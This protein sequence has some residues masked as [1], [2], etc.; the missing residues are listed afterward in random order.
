MKKDESIKEDPLM[1]KMDGMRKKWQ[2]VRTPG[3]LNMKKDESIKEDPLMPKMNLTQQKWQTE[4]K[5][6]HRCFKKFINSLNSIASRQS[7]GYHIQKFM[8]FCVKENKIT[9]N[10]EFEE[11]LDFDS[12]QITDL[13]QDYVDYLQEEGS[14]AVPTY[15]TAVEL[16]FTMNRKIWHNKVV[17]KGI[18]ELDIQ[19]AGKLPITDEEIELVYNGCKKPRDKALISFLG[20]LG[21]RPGAVTDPVMRFKHLIPIDDCYGIKVYDESKEGYWG[22]VIPEARK[23]IDT[24]KQSRIRN[25]EIITEESPIFATYPKIHKTKYNHLNCHTIQ[26][27]LPHLIKGKVE[28]KI[29]HGDRYDKAITYMFRKRF[30]QILGLENSVNSNIAELCMGHK[31]PGSQHTYQSGVTLEQ[32]YKALKPAFESLTIDSNVRKDIALEKVTKELEKVTGE[33]EER[34]F[35]RLYKGA[36]RP[37]L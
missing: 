5:E 16:F 28:R 8:K 36:T 10:T 13:L 21:I 12:E 14:K 32:V 22:I 23:D 1:P 27:L 15:L 17:R 18:T 7:Y 35:N 4:M 26:H 31:L 11:L 30:S 20:C 24:Y 29:V 33:M 6:K 34:L 3:M 19:R 37:E 2:T 25:G 9:G